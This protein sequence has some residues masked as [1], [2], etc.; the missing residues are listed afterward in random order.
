M[1]TTFQRIGCDIAYANGH[2]DNYDEN[3]DYNGHHC[4]PDHNESKN[5]CQG[6]NGEEN[7]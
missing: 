6:P 3:I 7:S 2:G 5:D 4:H 1:T